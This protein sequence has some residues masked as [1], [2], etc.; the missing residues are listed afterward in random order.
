MYFIGIHTR[1]TF[2]CAS[3]PTEERKGRAHA[4]LLFFVAYL[5]HLAHMHYTLRIMVEAPSVPSAFLYLHFTFLGLNLP[6]WS[7][8]LLSVVHVLL[9]RATT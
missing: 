4:N 1:Q 9:L 7:T 6:H 2:T 8:R 3:H 5:V